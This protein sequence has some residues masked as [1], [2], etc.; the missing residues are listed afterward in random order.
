ME[1]RYQTDQLRKIKTKKFK[2]FPETGKTTFSKMYVHF[3]KTQLVK[4]KGII[5]RIV[6]RNYVKMFN[7]TNIVKYILNHGNQKTDA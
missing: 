3:T 6:Y 2:G 4:K 7:W 1:G 5:S